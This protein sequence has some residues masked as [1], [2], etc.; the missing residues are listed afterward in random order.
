MNDYFLPSQVVEYAF[1]Q[2]AERW[3]RL[4]YVHAYSMEQSCNLIV[5]ACA[6]HNLYKR[7]NELN[8]DADDF[9]VDDDAVTSFDIAD[10]SSTNSIRDDIMQSL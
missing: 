8:F 5:A 10:D 4:K 1:G 6:L 9:L 7:N 2:L 3:R